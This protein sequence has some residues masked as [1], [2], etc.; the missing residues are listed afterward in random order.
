MLGSRRRIAV[1]A[2]GAVGAA[3]I[4]AGGVAATS[5]G[6]D[7]AA[8]LASAINKRAGTSITAEDVT[9]AYQDLLKA[10]LDE[11]VAAGRITRE[12]ADEMLQRAQDRGGLPGLGGPGMGRGHGPVFG[13]AEILAPVATRLGITEAQLRTRLR[14][15]SSLASIAAARKVSRAEL[16]ATI[17]AALVADGVPADEAADKAAHIA[18]DTHRG[19]GPGGLRG[20]RP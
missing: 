16:I 19:R 11:A 13:H 7:E 20:P 6:A 15:G 18:D 9:G 2:A 8:D 5:G 17:E 3:A 10:R 12:Q 4:A 1:I 14:D